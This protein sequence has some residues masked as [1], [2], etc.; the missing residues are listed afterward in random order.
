M[1]TFWQLLA[2]FGRAFIWWVVVQPWEQGL[3]I[4][5]G[6]R[7]VVL[8]PGLHMRIPYADAVYKQSVRLRLSAMQFQTLTTKDGHT[9]TAAA[10]LA[11][12]IRDVRKLY[13]TIHHAEDTIRNM[14]AGAI[15]SFVH[16]HPRAEVTPG[17]LATAATHALDLEQY[18]IGCAQVRIV[19]FAYVKTY[20]LIS[21]QK[22][23]QFGDALNTVISDRP[24]VS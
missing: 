24:V 5:L 15:A 18:G 23:S 21:D 11:Y 22:Y 19:D 9:L 3:R 10:T 7:V 16:E 20:R 4:R 2:Q 6:K 8:A 1:S 17:T 14:A 12:C 13:D